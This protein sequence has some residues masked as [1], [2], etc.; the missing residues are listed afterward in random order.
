MSHTMNSQRR[1]QL[2]LSRTEAVINERLWI[3]HSK[4]DVDGGDLLVRTPLTTNAWPAVS[5][6]LIRIQ[7][8]YRSW[9]SPAQIPISYVEQN[10][11]ARPDF[12]LFIHTGESPESPRSWFFDAE[13]ITQNAIRSKDNKVL[14]ITIKDASSYLTHQRD[15]A[16]ILNRLEKGIDA[17]T[18]NLATELMIRWK[19]PAANLLLQKLGYTNRLYDAFHVLDRIAFSD[20]DLIE[21]L[22]RFT[23]FIDECG[24][25][26]PFAERLG[27]A[28]GVNDYIRFDYEICSHNI[29]DAIRLGT[30]LKN[31]KIQLPPRLISNIQTTD[32]NQMQHNYPLS[33]GFGRKIRCRNHLNCFG[34][35]V[36][37]TLSTFWRE[38]SKTWHSGSRMSQLDDCWK[39]GFLASNFTPYELRRLEHLGLISSLSSV[40][41]EKDHVLNRRISIGQEAF[42]PTASWAFFSDATIS[43]YS[44]AAIELTPAGSVI[45]QA[46]QTEFDEILGS[47]TREL[48]HFW[49]TGYC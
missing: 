21:R 38:A 11:K 30:D 32:A 26:F 19:N 34:T 15:N 14:T 46:I 10:G 47:I 27:Y 35:L 7:V 3:L 42:T 13:E 22:S 4:I 5:P 23:V 17:T 44:S 49:E 31:G 6:N 2:G 33:D 39:Q 25:L 18:Q 45:T 12:F 8:K 36:N 16:F 40:K 1:E 37:G 20:I 48:I 41:L 28:N 29:P 9:N 24:H 43:R